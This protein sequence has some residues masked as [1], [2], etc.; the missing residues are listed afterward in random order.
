[1]WTGLD[2]ERFYR[3]LDN[4][5]LV[6]TF[7]KIIRGFFKLMNIRVSKLTAN[8]SVLHAL[9]FWRVAQNP[10]L[11]FTWGTE[12]HINVNWKHGTHFADNILFFTAT[13][14]NS[15]ADLHPCS[16]SSHRVVLEWHISPRYIY[17]WWL[18]SMRYI[19]SVFFFYW[20]LTILVE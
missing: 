18:A 14:L 13:I 6:K 9:L 19:I 10:G 17:Y 4:F 5:I 3:I 15:F 20:Y 1:M 7:N 16:R 11:F 2:I 12:Q 8:L